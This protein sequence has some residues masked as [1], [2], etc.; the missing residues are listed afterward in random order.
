MSKKPEW[1]GEYEH[2]R[3]TQRHVVFAARGKTPWKGE[4]GYIYMKKS[5][6]DKLENPEV[7]QLS[8]N[9][10]FPEIHLD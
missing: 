4:I 6:W 3:Q 8:I 10:R 2:I 9:A 5:L 1:S 7:I